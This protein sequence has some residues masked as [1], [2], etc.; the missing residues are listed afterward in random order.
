M[1]SSNFVISTRNIEGSGTS[2]KFG[3]EP[4]QALYLEVAN[5]E[6]PRPSMG[7]SD[8]KEW[9][10]ALIERATTGH[11]PD[12]IK[13]S[14]SGYR[15]GD[16]LIFVHGFN[17]SMEDVMK[18]HDLLQRNLYAEGYQGAI[19]SFDWPSAELTLGYM[20]DR[21][22][23]LATARQLV[24]KG[25]KILARSQAQQEENK[26]DIDIHLLGHS[27]GAYVIRE[28][29]YLADHSGSI[30]RTNWQVSQIALIGGDISRK[31]MA[32]DNDKS[33]AMFTHAMRITNYQNPYDIPLKV[34]SVKR[35]GTAP[36]VGRVGLPDDP[37]QNVVNVHVGDYWQE[38]VKNAP[39]SE[40]P[41]NK[42]HSWHFGDL[43]FAQD[44]VHTLT[45]DI[46]RNHIPTREIHQGQLRLKV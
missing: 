11:H 22:D 16:I 45:G 29:F 44:L 39:D 17:N 35:L 18:R 30:S 36:R 21:S 20:E 23:A 9:L 27:T 25:I 33:Q 7:T 12:N 46:D 2:A 1:D 41:G 19:V 4:G 31:A 3:T 43:G 15:Q 38:H 37:P 40:A 24:D 13:N 8:P 5:G 34:S 6:I 26:C 28:G 42:T 10:A 14:R 32:Y